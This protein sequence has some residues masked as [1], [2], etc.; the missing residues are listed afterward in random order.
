[1]KPYTAISISV[2][3]LVALSHLLRLIFGWAMTVQGVSIP[4]WVSVVGVVVPAGLAM[5]LYREMKNEERKTRRAV[6]H[7]F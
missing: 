4:M 3:T 5:M 7:Q 2:F 6:A 1:M